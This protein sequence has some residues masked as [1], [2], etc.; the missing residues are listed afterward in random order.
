MDTSV[1]K[2]I[3]EINKNGIKPAYFLRGDDFYLQKFFTSYLNKKFDNSVKVK[4]IDLSDSNDVDLFLNDLNSMSLFTCKNIFS[5]RNFSRLSSDNKKYLIKYFDKPND[6]MLL[7]FVLDDYALKNKFSKDVHENC[8]QVDTN[9]PFFASK[10]K[11][12]T[13]YYMQLNN[14]KLDY[15]VI[16]DLV[17]SYGDNIANV[18]NEVEKLFLITNKRDIKLDDYSSTYK[19]RNLKN[20][21]LMNALGNKDLDQ[22]IYIFDTLIING[23]SLVPIV[24]NLYAFYFALLNSFYKQ[25]VNDYRLNKTIQTKI[26]SF[27]NRY[28]II[29]I[30]N[31][32]IELRN[33]DV[34][35]KSTS[36]DS[37]LLFHPFIIKTCKGYYDSE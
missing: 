4:Y 36:L 1:G 8:V 6:D 34:L 27:Q 33:I 22:S 3:R 16:D 7:L 29:E 2:A 17:S 24:S 15:H 37:K 23:I 26:P 12:W 35:I 28:N 19:N 18:V 11:D 21:H 32:I 9:T 30:S 5:I 10:I 13:K 31:I 14:I 25:K 20:W